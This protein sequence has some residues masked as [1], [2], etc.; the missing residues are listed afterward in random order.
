L[1]GGGDDLIGKICGGGKKLGKKIKHQFLS[2][3]PALAVLRKK[4]EHA[5]KKGWIKTLMVAEY[6][7]AVH[8]QHLTFCY[9][10]LAL[11]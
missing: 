2:N 1:Y 4:I 5:S 3:T 11:S 8:T 7:S 9:R 10:V 6:M